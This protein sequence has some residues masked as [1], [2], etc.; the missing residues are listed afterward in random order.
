M[1][2]REGKLVILDLTKSQYIP[3]VKCFHD[4]PQV[5][6]FSLWTEKGERVDDL[7]RIKHDTQR[8]M[9]NKNGKLQPLKIAESIQINLLEYLKFKNKGEFREFK[10]HEF[11]YFLIHGSLDQSNLKYKIQ[12]TEDFEIGDTVLLGA[13]KK[14]LWKTFTLNVVHSVICIEYKDEEPL[15]ISKLGPDRKIVITTLSELKKIYWESTSCAKTI[16]KN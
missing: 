15:F 8:I 3:I 6:V 7:E 11:S 14:I 5:P 10:C 12:K 13:F 16:W 4:S 9:V 2:K 1:S